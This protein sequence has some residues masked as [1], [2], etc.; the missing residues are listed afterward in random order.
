MIK[1]MR[2]FL[3]TI[4]LIAGLCL[5]LGVFAQV[6][7]EQTYPEI[8]EEGGEVVQQTLTG[9]AQ[10]P[11]L[12]KY[13]T[14]WAIILAALAVVVSLVIGGI[15]YLTSSGRPEAMSGA[16]GRITNS[17][18]G[19]AI[20]AASYLVLVT[21][22]PQ[23][24]VLSLVVAPVDS[25]IVLFTETGYNDFIDSAKQVSLNDLL[26]AGQVRMLNSDIEDLTEEV[27]PLVQVKAGG[28][29]VEIGGKQKVNF[30]N[31]PLYALGFWGPPGGFAENVKVKAYNG[32]DFQKTG[33][34]GADDEPPNVYLKGGKAISD[35]DDT[36]KAGRGA[37]ARGSRPEVQVIWIEQNLAEAAL[38]PENTDFF[39]SKAR[40]A[41]MD[42]EEYTEKT[43]NKETIAWED[44]VQVYHPPLSIMVQGIGPGVYLYSDQGGQRYLLASHEDFGLSDIK[45]D[46]M[47][48]K[49]EVNN[50]EKDDKLGEPT[51]NYLAIL[52]D[53]YHFAGNLR[54][55]FT[56]VKADAPEKP[57]IPTIYLRDEFKQ[58]HVILCTEPR[59]PGDEGE[60]C[61]EANTSNDSLKKVGE[62]YSFAAN[63]HRYRGTLARP[64]NIDLVTPAGE[65]KKTIK[66]EIND[67]EDVYGRIKKSAKASSLQFF[68]IMPAVS[69]KEDF[70]WTDFKASGNRAQECREV[71]ICTEKGGTG[72]CISYTPAGKF[73]PGAFNSITLPMPYFAPVNIPEKLTGIVKTNKGEFK[74][75][76]KKKFA[77]K[78][79]SLYIRGDCL[80]VLFENALDDLT[81]DGNK[82]LA[83]SWEGGTPGS[84]SEVFLKTD[85]DLT[86]N[87]IARCGS[88]SGIG[89]TEPK[90]CASA[91]AV[92]PIRIIE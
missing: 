73:F 92:F 19:L 44:K 14:N 54:L 91:I 1:L 59:V 24:T 30:A 42:S 25:G 48:D 88:A 79:K 13:F 76:D 90:G 4:L 60:T 9:K 36:I 6:E 84:H 58:E 89:L 55:F 80:V 74:K 83:G 70:E 34:D 51:H 50:Y 40:Y 67:I 86:D 61:D 8:T 17:F 33:L 38:R 64:G 57:H 11:D 21:I 2:K 37:V 65:E 10:L 29:V 26:R 72:D 66:V 46:N 27:G 45:F 56:K 47:A 39:L 22:N 3:L 78:I 31:F 20:L 16:R 62:I 28:N 82:N 43:K 69:L 85:W 7:L 18:L 12:I 32:K 53:Y 15:Q 75:A 81:V 49:I 5:A 87:E 41:L 23:L 71:R 77:D 35:D 63:F 68:E 52:H